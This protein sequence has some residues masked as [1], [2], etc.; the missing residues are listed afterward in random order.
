MAPIRMTVP[1]GA[2]E[3]TADGERARV[4][5]EHLGIA[6]HPVELAADRLDLRVGQRMELGVRPDDAEVG[7]DHRHAVGDGVEDLVGLDQH[8]RPADRRELRGVD[9]DAREVLLAEQDQ[10][11]RHGPRRDHVVVLGQVLARRRS[12][13]ILAFDDQESR[14]VRHSC[15]PA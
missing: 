5:A 15:H 7:I 11:P 1:D 14:L 12:R 4:G 9:V 3:V 6:Q 13:R 2:R 8:A 10:G